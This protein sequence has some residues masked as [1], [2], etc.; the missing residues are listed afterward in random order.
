MSKA[1]KVHVCSDDHTETIGTAELV[2]SY[3]LE[4]DPEIILRGVTFDAELVL[5]G[6]VRALQHDVEYYK[7]ARDEA[8]AGSMP[9]PTN[10]DL[11]KA[12]L[13]GIWDGYQTMDSVARWLDDSGWVP[14]GD[15]ENQED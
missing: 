13:S 5:S 1:V 8:I 6:Q 9:R 10:A 2:E 4:D 14:S 3:L 7:R 12:D 15:T 11:L